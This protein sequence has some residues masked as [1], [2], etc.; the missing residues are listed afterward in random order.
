MTDLVI[1]KK[2]TFTTKYPDKLGGKFKNMQLEA[3]NMSSNLAVN[4]GDIHVIH[5]RIKASAPDYDP[6]KNLNVENL[7]WLVFLNLDTK[8]HTLLALEYLDTNSISVSG[9]TYKFIVTDISVTD[10]SVI[11]KAL[12]ELGYHID[13]LE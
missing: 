9:D 4:Y 2:Y 13:D 11:K 1:G 6:I 8:K 12:S 5:Q 7:T 10:V 3:S